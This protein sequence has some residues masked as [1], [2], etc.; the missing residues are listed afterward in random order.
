MERRFSITAANALIFMPPPID[1]DAH[2]THIMNMAMSSVEPS[3]DSGPKVEKPAVRTVV[4][5][6]ILCMMRLP[7][8]SP[9]MEW[10]YSS[11]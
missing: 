1:C 2:P 7:G 3:H 9:S 5:Q 10:L 6:N 4:A 11:T 8:L